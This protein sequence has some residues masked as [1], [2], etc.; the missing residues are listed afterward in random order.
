MWSPILHLKGTNAMHN[1][2]PE[3]LSVV[4]EKVETLRFGVVQVVVHDSKIIQIERTERIRID[5]ATNR[6]APNQLKSHRPDTLEDK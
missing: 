1:N 5:G 3:W 6:S 2:Q 4:R